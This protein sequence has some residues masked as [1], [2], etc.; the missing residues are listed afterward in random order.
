[1]AAAE[2][3]R[4]AKRAQP[5]RPFSLRLVDGTIYEVRHPDMISIPPTRRPREVIYYLV[6]NS[7]SEDYQTRFIDMGLVMEVIVPSSSRPQAN[8]AG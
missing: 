5:F 1:M 7:E 6:E 3:I 2:T 4:E 8:A